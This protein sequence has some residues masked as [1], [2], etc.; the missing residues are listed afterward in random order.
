MEGCYQS[1]DWSLQMRGIFIKQRN[2]VK[3]KQAG[4]SALLGDFLTRMGILKAFI[5]INMLHMTIYFSFWLF[6]PGG[7]SVQLLILFQ[8]GNNPQFSDGLHLAALSDTKRGSPLLQVERWEE[9][10]FLHKPTAN[11]MQE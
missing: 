5:R 10:E 1:S 8:F 6:F 4:I 7:K 3:Y 11:Q 2:Q 9:A